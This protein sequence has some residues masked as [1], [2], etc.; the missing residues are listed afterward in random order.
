MYP[1]SPKYLEYVQETARGWDLYIDVVLA[2]GTQLKLTRSEIDL[3]TF[4]FKDGATCS[5]TIQIGSTYSNSVEFRV[6]N[7]EGQFTDYDFYL[8]KLYPYVGLDL[9]GEEDFEYVPLGEFNVLEPAKKF[10]TISVVGF[11][12][13][14]LTNRTFDFSQMVFPTQPI[15]VFDEVVAQCG[16]EHDESLRN[17]IAELTYEIHSL[18]TNEPTC[19][20]VLA[21]F[22]I[23][24]LKNLRFNRSGVLEAFWYQSFGGQTTRYT[25][26]GNS[27]YGDL[28]ITTTGVYMEDAYGNAFSVGTGEYA[29]ELPSSPIVQGSDM[30]NPILEAAL[31][32]LQALPYRSASITWIGDPAV[33]AGDIVNHVETAVGDL[34]LPIMR[35]VYKFA[36]TE[37]IESLGMNGPTKSQQSVTDRRLRKAFSKSDQDKAELLTKIDQTADE[38]LIQVSE[39]YADKASLASVS[40][41]V[42]S[43]TSEVK[44]QE[45]TLEG[46]QEDLLTV[47]QS[48][49]ELS[50]TI[51]SVIDDG[52]S[53]VVTKAA[54]YTL[55]DEGLKIAKPG[56][57]MENKL[58]HTGMYVARSGE[59]MLQAN[60]DGVVATDV[61]V[62]NYL[63]I[64]EHTRVEDYNDGV[65]TNRTAVFYIS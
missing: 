29:V 40:I 39:Q 50:V 65:D 35:L 46:L 31:E 36:G 53:K 23:M 59:I 55:D 47:Q 44:K 25:R 33:Q 12:N 9:T 38:V 43:V 5:S 56:E 21:G 45:S 30:C 6:I 20:D 42:D 48:A 60:N 61:K 7:R 14:S 18:L 22:G 54:K 32:L 34:A 3:G 4:L 41:K 52:V 10:S 49:T 19:R 13:M 1:V 27:S 64:G 51:Q 26:V 58:D 15:T 62:R 63:V 8:A 17:Q 57:E 2:D 37:T 28:Q 24:L 11:D 16:I